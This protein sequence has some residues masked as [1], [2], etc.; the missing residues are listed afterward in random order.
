[1]KKIFNTLKKAYQAD[2]TFLIAGLGNPG[3]EY[4]HNRHNVGFMVVDQVAKQLDVEFTRVQNNALVTKAAYNGAK[5]I[6]VKPRTY[7]NNSGKA[8]ASLLR[9]YKIPP[10]NLLVIYDDVDLDFEIIRLRAEGGS[11]GQKGM[12]SI[13][14]Q[15][16][17]QKFPRLR[18]GIGR[19]PGKMQTP[20]YVLQDF[21]SQQREALPWMLERAAQAALGFVTTGIIQA[22]NDF[23]TSA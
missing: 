5:L 12:Q 16:G 23:N 21:S 2:D 10:K 9:F 7:M 19:P 13:I 14:Q 20:D 6:L 11:A 18:V 17:T 15:L 1:M 22:M 8:V 4:Q 3:R